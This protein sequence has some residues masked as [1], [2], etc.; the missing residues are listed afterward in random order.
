MVKKLPKIYKI[1]RISVRDKRKIDFTKKLFY[2]SKFGGQILNFARQIL[3]QSWSHSKILT[4]D[5]FMGQNL[6]NMGV[7]VPRAPVGG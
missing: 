4:F 5:Q 1:A 6:S 2:F 7:A 3:E